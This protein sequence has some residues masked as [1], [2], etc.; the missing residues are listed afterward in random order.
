MGRQRD[1]IADLAL[2]DCFK[3]GRDVT[4][5]AGAK[6]GSGVMTG[7]NAP[8]SSRSASTCVPI[9]KMRAPFIST[10]SITRT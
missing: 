2:A 8:T 7:R 10:P 1:G 9:S 4:D 3:T 6:L 5:F